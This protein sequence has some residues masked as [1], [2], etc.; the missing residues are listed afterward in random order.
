M[1]VALC[2]RN[3]QINIKSSTGSTLTSE[4]TVSRTVHFAL[5]TTERVQGKAAID[6][7]GSRVGKSGGSVIQQL[8]VVMFGSM[9]NAAPC[10]AAI[11]YTVLVLWLRAA[12]KLSKLFVSKTSGLEVGITSNDDDQQQQE[13]EGKGKQ[14]K[15]DKYRQ[16]VK[17]D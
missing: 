10:V 17:S 12:S 2:R 4:L 13:G 14:D 1:C 6:V 11:F 5:F 16:R 15:Q 3:R 9:M 8:L 7:L